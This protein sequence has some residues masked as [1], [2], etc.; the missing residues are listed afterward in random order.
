MYRTYA[1]LEDGGP[2][3]RVGHATKKP[4]PCLARLKQY[5]QAEVRV[6]DDQGKEHLFAVVI[7]HTIHTL[8]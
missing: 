1:R 2:L 8:H 5:S 3:V 4:D 6:L 7:G